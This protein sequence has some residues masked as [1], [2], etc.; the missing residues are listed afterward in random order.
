MKEDFH[1]Q[2]VVVPIA[3]IFHTIFRSRKSSLCVPDCIHLGCSV[4]SICVFKIS[5]QTKHSQL[6]K[7]SMP[8][9]QAH[10]SPPPPPSLPFTTDTGPPVCISVC[11]APTGPKQNKTKRKSQSTLPCT[12]SRPPARGLQSANKMASKLGACVLAAQLHG[13]TS[14][15]ASNPGTAGCSPGKPTPL[16]KDGKKGIQTEGWKGSA[17]TCVCAY[18]TCGCVCVCVCVC[19]CGAVP[20]LFGLPGL[21]ALL[22]T[23]RA[24]R[25][26]WRNSVPGGWKEKRTHEQRATLLVAFVSCG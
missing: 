2:F 1:F 14:V 12:W 8:F 21:S 13:C 3:A 18:G 9:L 5:F 24:V 6:H 19:L 11:N 22:K 15:R 26:T 25:P 4:R 7:I 17:A 20:S 23:V 10:N 16:R